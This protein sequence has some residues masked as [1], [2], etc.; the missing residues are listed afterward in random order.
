MRPLVLVYQEIAQPQA[1]PSAPDL[2]S[3]IV[4]PCYV[5]KDYP[6]DANETLLTQTYG[7]KEQPAGGSGQYVPPASGTDAL[8]LSSYPGNSPGAL[9][10]KTSVRLTLRFPRVAMGATYAGCGTV[11]GTSATTYNTT[12]NENLV[13]VTGADFVAAGVKAGDRVILTDS[14]SVTVLRVVRSVGEPDSSGT[15]TN[16]E[17]LRL[18]EN[19][20]SSGWTFGATEIRIERVLDTQ[21]FVDPTNAYVTFPEANTDKMVLKGGITL[22]VTVGSTVVAKPLSYAEV[23]VS[24][25]ALRQDLTSVVSVTDAD[26]RTS[27]GIASILNIGKIDARNPAAV[28]LSVALQCSG[29]APVYFFGVQTDDVNGHAI[30]REAMSSRRDLYCFAVMTQDVNIIGGYKAEWDNL[31]SPTYALDNGVPQLFR[32]VIGNME[33]PKATTIAPNSIVGE[34]QQQT[35]SGTGLY[36]TLTFAGSPTISL[37]QV[38]PGDTLTIGL[39]PGTGQWASR[40][41]VHRVSHVNSSLQIELEPGTSRWNNSTGDSAGG[42]EAMIVSPN[43]TVKFKRVGFVE[44][45]ES[46][47]GI[48]VETLAP[49][50]TGGPYRLRLVDTGSVVPTVGIVGFDITVGFDAGVTTRQAIVDALNASAV[51]NTVVEASLVGSDGA[52]AA[53]VPFTSL[54]TYYVQRD[55]IDTGSDGIRVRLRNGVTSPTI[56]YNDT[57]SGP[58]VSV[59]GNAITVSYDA[60]TSTL[61]QIVNAI[62]ADP[63]ASALVIASL[64]ASSITSTAALDALGLQTISQIDQTYINGAVAVNDDL[65]LRLSDSTAQFITLGVRVGDVIEIPVNPNDYAPTAFSGRLLSYRVAQLISENLLLVENLGDDTPSVAKELPHGYARDIPD[66][67]IDN[68][69][70]GSPAAAQNYRIRRTLTKDE[71]ILAMIAT[72]A[73][74]NSS[75]TV[76]TF[77]DEVT[78]TDLK[79]GSLP[80]TSATV[81]TPAGR[82]K[83]YYLGAQVAGA[84]A[85]LPP[86]HGLTLLGLPGLDAVHNSSNFFR[87]NQLA[88]LSDGGVWVVL[89]PTPGTLPYC[90]HQLTTNPTTLQGG[91]FSMVKNIDFVSI[92]LQRNLEGFLGQYNVLPETI[93]DILQSINAVTSDL[94]SRKVAKI[95]PP[96]LSGEVTKIQEVTGFSSRIEAFFKGKIPSPLNNIDL[97]VIF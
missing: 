82:Q 45:L 36:R 96:L 39:T 73:S 1:T 40:R 41:G 3:V 51:S 54:L 44:M 77:P 95:G 14:A 7:E 78:V 21:L 93:D 18:T 55:S 32:T 85:G 13:D 83:G 48:R 84:V 71:Q 5:I 61:T 92:F 58:T 63:D 10:D 79:D 26:R 46:S 88:L 12:G 19:L 11:Y 66:L 31:A 29:G 56:E 17:R 94:T 81:L 42:I 70:A 2:N 97:R 65:Y 34:A 23:Y 57:G 28:A 25:R 64:L 62:N 60:G 87:E 27:G 24:Y 6:E 30:A 38:L 76:L 67:L 49:T 91:E 8:T 86:Q 53:A 43:G 68:N 20:P 47:N 52:V 80:R 33:L 74:F 50:T 35:S 59:T 37:V 4:A 22:N 75:R 89:Q 69:P 9:L 72:A 16:A 90:M 15:P